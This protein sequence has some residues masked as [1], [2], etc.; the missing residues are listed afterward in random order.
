VYLSFKGEQRP[1]S[2]L[3]IALDMDL[4]DLYGDVDDTEDTNSEIKNEKELR[5][6]NFIYSSTA[7]EREYFNMVFNNNITESKFI[8][9][10][11][12]EQP[13]GYRNNLFVPFIGNEGII[14]L[15]FNIRY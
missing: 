9:K 3:D 1:R 6:E 10:N 2:F 11:Y 8:L 14:V 7:Q 4:S 15:L 12:R 5:R 13:F